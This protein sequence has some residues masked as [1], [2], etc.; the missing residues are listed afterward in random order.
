MRAYAV[1]AGV[2][3]MASAV[4][5][6]CGE[7]PLSPG[8]LKKDGTR[9]TEFTAAHARTA[10]AADELVQLYCGGIESDARRLG[11]LSHV[12]VE[13]VCEADTGA[14]RWAIDEYEAA[15]GANPCV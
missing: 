14:R 5:T 9:S 12:T 1:L 10:A 7:R 15:Y 13:D 8:P 2:L 3:L 4:V 6:T 11:C